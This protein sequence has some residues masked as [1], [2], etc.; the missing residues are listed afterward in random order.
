MGME[1][2]VECHVV[3]RNELIEGIGAKAR[4]LR[5]G[6][7]KVEHGIGREDKE[8]LLTP[9]ADPRILGRFRSSD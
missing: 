7:S 8:L 4:D 2:R 5:N 3:M 9:L 6:K 1:R